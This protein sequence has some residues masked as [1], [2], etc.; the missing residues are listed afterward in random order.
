M[1]W[2]KRS[3]KHIYRY[4]AVQNSHKNAPEICGGFANAARHGA[5]RGTGTESFEARTGSSI[6]VVA[7]QI[8]HSTEI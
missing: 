1:S 7:I 5:S 3:A 6:N 2:T 8:Y 4:Q